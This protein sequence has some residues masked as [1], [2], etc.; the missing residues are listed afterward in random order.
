MQCMP[1]SLRNKKYYFP[2]NRGNEKNIKV[3]LNNI[4][5]IKKGKKET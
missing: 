3:I 1:T 4:E 2:S 5:R